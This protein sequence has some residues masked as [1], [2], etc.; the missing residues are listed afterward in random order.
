MTTIARSPGDC[1]I[2]TVEHSGTARGTTEKIAGVD[3]YISRPAELGDK[4]KVILFFADVYGP[5]FL[6]SQ[7]IMDYWASNGEQDCLRMGARRG[8]MVAQ[9]T[10]C[11]LWTT[12]R[13]TRCRTICIRS[14]RTTASSST[15]CPVR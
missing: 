5:F 8:L 10:W 9:A 7:L 1:C 6:N 2:K 13:A 11:L 12:L 4:R 14:G 15:S 3:T